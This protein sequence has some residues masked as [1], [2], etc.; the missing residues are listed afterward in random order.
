LL[1]QLLIHAGMVAPKYAHTHDRN[2]NWIVNA[3][4]RPLRPLVAGKIKKL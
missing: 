2:R 1:F 4:R 3:Q